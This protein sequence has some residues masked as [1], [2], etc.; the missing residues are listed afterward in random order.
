MI[1]EADGW[2]KYRDI[3]DV[4][5]EKRRE[6]ALRQA[7]FIVVRWTWDELRRHPERVMARLC[8]AINA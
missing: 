4:R 8:Q 2:V 6:D 5:A 7:G 3:D 1:G